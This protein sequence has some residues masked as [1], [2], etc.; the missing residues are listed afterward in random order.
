M[1]SP[2][3]TKVPGEMHESGKM[4]AKQKWDGA[5]NV[6]AV[7]HNATQTEAGTHY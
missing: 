4:R 2:R 7:E 1:S 3:V 5:S 6:R